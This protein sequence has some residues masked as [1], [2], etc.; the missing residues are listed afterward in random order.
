MWLC[1]R[2]GLCNLKFKCVV[3]HLH[4]TGLAK[5]VQAPSS[6]VSRAENAVSAL[7]VEMVFTGTKVNFLWDRK[8]LPKIGF[9]WTVPIPALLCSLAQPVGLWK[10]RALVQ[11]HL[12]FTSCSVFSPS[13]SGDFPTQNKASQ[14]AAF[15]HFFLKGGRKE[16]WMGSSSSGSYPAAATF[17]ARLMLMNRE[18]VTHDSGGKRPLKGRSDTKSGLW[19]IVLCP[20]S[21][22]GALHG[23]GPFPV[24]FSCLTAQAGLYTL[25]FIQLLC[26]KFLL[27]DLL[28]A[29][30]EFL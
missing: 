18:R 15:C 20:L 8:T 4:A 29:S 12:W 17:S 16:P 27:Q 19:W 11:G 28:P 23:P 7:G 25:L 6:C 9:Q 5:S 2:V 26:S 22:P 14:A 10:P 24:E 3:Q 1:E 30:W 13:V 21:L